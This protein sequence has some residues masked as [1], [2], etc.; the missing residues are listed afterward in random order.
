MDPDVQHN[1]LCPLLGS[2]RTMGCSS[3]AYSREQCLLSGALPHPAQPSLRLEQQS[4]SP[5]GVVE[6]DTGRAVHSPDK[7]KERES[8]S[9]RPFRAKPQTHRSGSCELFQIILNLFSVIGGCDINEFQNSFF[10]GKLTEDLLG[11]SAVGAGG[12]DEHHHFPRLDFAVHKLL[13]HADKLLPPGEES[14]IAGIA[15]E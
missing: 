14:S 13:S 10:E 15:L 11:L 3:A 1:Q 6:K 4:P 5:S 12:L 2:K 9:S 8:L 7:K